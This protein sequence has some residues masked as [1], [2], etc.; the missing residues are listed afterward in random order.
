M[1]L[2]YFY[3]CKYVVTIKK[4]IISMDTADHNIRKPHA[5]VFPNPYQLQLVT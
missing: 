1:L 4:I 5:I 3:Q 2:L